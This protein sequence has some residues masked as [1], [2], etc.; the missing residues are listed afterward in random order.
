MTKF[1]PGDLVRLT[2]SHWPKNHNH[3]LVR[4][5]EHRIL[6]VNAAG[7]IL[8]AATKHNRYYWI[9][10]GDWAIELVEEEEEQ[11]PMLEPNVRFA[12]QLTPLDLGPNRKITWIHKYRYAN[13]DREKMKTVFKP[14]GLNYN[15]RSNKNI[16]TISGYDSVVTRYSTTVTLPID[17]EVVISDI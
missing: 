9:V 12:V 1:K 7:N 15:S 14:Y 2:G 11:A 13:Q 8:F 4:N 17:T 5:S 3:G 16:I 10:S 6:D